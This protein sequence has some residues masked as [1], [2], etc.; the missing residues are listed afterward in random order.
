MRDGLCKDISTSL[1]NGRGRL[2]KPVSNLLS[3]NTV[4]YFHYVSPSI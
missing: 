4:I 1:M 3:Q 2:L